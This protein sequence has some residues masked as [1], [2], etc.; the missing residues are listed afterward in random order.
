MDYFTVSV[1]TTIVMSVPNINVNSSEFSF[2][3]ETNGIR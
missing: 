2:S 1:L 3:F